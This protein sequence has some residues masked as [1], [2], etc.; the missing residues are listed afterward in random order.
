MRAVISVASCVAGVIVVTAT[1]T[2]GGDWGAAATF[3]SVVFCILSP[4]MVSG[5]LTCT[6]GCVIFFARRVRSGGA[7]IPGASEALET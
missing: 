2:R 5:A 7:S 6:L 1:E 4:G 3:G